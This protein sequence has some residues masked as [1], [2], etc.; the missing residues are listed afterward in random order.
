M[1]SVCTVRKL[2][3]LHRVMTNEES[4]CYRA[5]SA[6]VDNV[7][8]LSLVKECRDLEERYRSDF[9]SQILNATDFTASSY[10]LKVAEDHIVKEDKILQLKKTSQF[11]HLNA[12]ADSV[13]W[14]K[15][16]DLALDHG[17]SGVKSVKN[18]VRIISYP[19]HASTK[20]PK[21]EIAELDPLS[22]P[23]HIIDEHTN[24]E[25]SWGTLLNSLVSMDPTF[26]SHVLCLLNV[27]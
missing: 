14:R 25:S 19:N 1:H 16:W 8:V 3:F 13:G 23:A 5:F 2:R 17:P 12:I 20:C 10:A 9:T 15:L 18:L 22:L 11:C 27:F 4:I 26:F 21:C 24:S 6:M 7:E